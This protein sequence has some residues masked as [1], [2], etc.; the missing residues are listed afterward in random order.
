MLIFSVLTKFEHIRY[1]TTN[2]KLPC[3]G[4]GSYKWLKVQWRT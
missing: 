2:L 4:R 3:H 1:P